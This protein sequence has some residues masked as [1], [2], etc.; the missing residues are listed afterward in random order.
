MNLGEVR[1]FDEIS[2]KSGIFHEIWGF[3]DLWTAATARGRFVL[4]G[5]VVF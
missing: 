4:A 2:R 3:G 5:N 1:I